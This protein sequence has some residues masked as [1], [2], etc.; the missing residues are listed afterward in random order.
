[1]TFP[2]GSS[3]PELATDPASA[4]PA[5]PEPTGASATATPPTQLP[6]SE[7]DLT[8]WR[9]EIDRSVKLRDGVISAWGVT[10]NLERYTPKSVTT[11]TK[12]SGE[13]NVGKDFSDVERK[14]AALFYDTP[15]IAMV[16]DPGTDGSVLQLHQELVN[17][18]LSA[19]RMD[20]KA[21]VLPT[22]QDCLVAIQPVPTEIGYSAVT[23]DM[24]ETQPGPPTPDPQTGQPVPGPP[25]PTGKMVPVPVWEEFFWRRI[26]PK[27]VLVPVTLKDTRYDEAPWIGYQWRKPRSVVK[28]QYKLADDWTG[29]NDSSLDKPYF[30]PLV[31][32]G[33]ESEPMVAGVKLWYRASLRDPNI[34]HPQVLRVL[35]LID[36]LPDPVVHQQVP[37]QE[38][39]PDG[40]LTPNSM[41]GLPCHP[42]AL[43]DLTDSPFVASDCTLTGPLTRELNTFRTQMIERRD[44]SKLHMLFDSAKINTE[45]RDKIENG[46]A[47]KMIP[48]EP[49]ALEGGADAIMQQVP[50]VQ[51]G[52]ESYMGQDVIER[53]R[54]GILG[55]NQNIT[56]P[57]GEGGKTATE[58]KTVQRNTDA[59]FEQERQRV[60]QWW[61]TGVQK[62][63]ALVLRYGDR[64][65][66]EIL[67]PQR[68]QAWV[69]ARDNGQFTRFSFE[70]VIDSGTFVDIEERKRQDI[71]LYNLTAKDPTLNRSTLQA[72][73]ATDFGIDPAGWIVTKPPEHKPD[74][75]TV[76]IAV[77]PED[78]D[79]MLPSY[80]GTF[81]I[82]TAGGVKGLPPPKPV[83]PPAPIAPLPGV[84]PHQG[85]PSQLE[86]LDQHQLDQTGQPPGPKVM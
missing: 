35:E 50:A 58:V 79:P 61:L 71:Q 82:L 30:E 12:M 3:V 73:I 24:P 7:E 8:F 33:E 2:P 46:S 4:V 20:A 62:V 44:A 37:Y 27:A 5:V 41:L 11:G 48:V 14:K 78:L 56:N 13:V 53:D 10:D 23:V 67:G 34:T 26:S 42:L 36:G 83:L 17:T 55:M 16:P 77:K 66:V 6:L 45:V 80:Q 81:A 28:Q 18:L 54:D 64:I 84:V 51:L 76:S 57:R 74:P 40:R 47:P 32:P 39:G 38:I 85:M 72:R 25:M 70:I 49:G 65:A 9:A 29:G 69:H 15:D 22:I 60:L 52:R 63:S 86:R 21:T 75:P 59:R 31:D 1:M 43:R 19:K 68:G